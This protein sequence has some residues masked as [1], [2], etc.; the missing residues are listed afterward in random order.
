M[1]KRQFVGGCFCPFVYVI[2]T[3]AQRPLKALTNDQ[4]IDLVYDLDFKV[5]YNSYAWREFQVREITGI[6]PPLNKNVS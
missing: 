6:I 1:Y 5:R 3:G 2:E 4:L